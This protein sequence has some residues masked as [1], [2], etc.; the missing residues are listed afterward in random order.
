MPLSAWKS[1]FSHAIDTEAEGAKYFLGHFKKARIDDSNST[2]STRISGQR[3]DIRLDDGITVIETADS[4]VV[5]L[6]PAPSQDVDEDERG[7]FCQPAGLAIF[8]KNLKSCSR[9]APHEGSDAQINAECQPSETLGGNPITSDIV[10]TENGMGR[11]ICRAWL[12][13]HFLQLGQPCKNANCKRRHVIESRSVGSLYKDYSFKGLSTAQRNSIISQVQAASNAAVKICDSITDAQH[14]PISAAVIRLAK[15]EDPPYSEYIQNPELVPSSSSGKSID[16]ESQPAETLADNSTNSD[17]VETENGM[18]RQICRAWLKNN[19]LQLGQ[20]CKNAKCE[21]LHVIESRSVGSLYKD[22]SFKGLSTA[23]R[24]SIISQ[25]Q[26]AS[27][28]IPI[29]KLDG[30]VTDVKHQPKLADVIV[31]DTENI[32][33]YEESPLRGREVVKAAMHPER[34]FASSKVDIKLETTS[35]SRKTEDNVARNARLILPK[36][37]CKPWMPIHKRITY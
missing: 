2:T 32:S 6:I 1:A 23:Q 10:E 28:S 27:G 12:K 25:V 22:Y 17:I 26:A 16:S 14:V 20:P 7:G 33:N 30:G 24:N 19:F 31:T 34:K 13:N 35:D 29:V 4:T 5:N 18:G 8:F 3:P 37:H 21:R 11:Q 36:P 15:T 9:N